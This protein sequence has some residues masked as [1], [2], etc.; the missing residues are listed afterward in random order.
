ML[1]VPYSAVIALPHSAPD[2]DPGAHAEALTL[3]LSQP[4]VP[5]LV[6]GPE[7]AL[8]RLDFSQC[9]NHP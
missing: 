9:P 1:D 2:L 8:K 4:R 6:E 7:F 5:T 3:I